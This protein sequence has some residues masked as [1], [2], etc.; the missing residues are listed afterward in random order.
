[1]IAKK[2]RPQNDI[3]FLGEY[4]QQALFVF[5]HQYQVEPYFN[6][7]DH[8]N[9]S[10]SYDLPWFFDSSIGL[11]P[12]ENKQFAYVIHDSPTK[13]SEIHIISTS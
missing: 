8:K 10:A 1:M 3:I 9:I 2:E 5:K 11:I 6:L 13:T 4:Y 12:I 7:R